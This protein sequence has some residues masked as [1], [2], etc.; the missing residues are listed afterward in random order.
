MIF[1]FISLPAIVPVFLWLSSLCMYCFLNSFTQHF[2][3]LFWLT[4][5][6]LLLLFSYLYFKDFLL[7]PKIIFCIMQFLPSVVHCSLNTGQ[8]AFLICHLVFLEDPTFMCTHCKSIFHFFY[9]VVILFHGIYLPPYMFSG[10]CHTTV[11]VKTWQYFLLRKVCSK[12]NC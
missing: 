2:I 12:K 3:L 9:S 11:T 5:P 7:S 8:T 10:T 4:S 1:G 6:R